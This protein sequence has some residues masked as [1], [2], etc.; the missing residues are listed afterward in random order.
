MQTGRRRRILQDYTME[1]IKPYKIK[2][3]LWKI[4][5]IYGVLLI[6]S[7]IVFLIYSLVQDYDSK[8]LAGNWSY[9]FFALQGIIFFTMGYMQLRYD[10]Y[11]IELNDSE[12]RYL[13]PKQKNIEHVKVVDIESVVIKLS[14]I[15][16]Y[17]GRET[18]TIPLSNLQYAELK[19]IKNKFEEINV[20][21]NRKSES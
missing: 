6:I 2:K 7:A 18:K 14:E 19:R 8:F 15:Q 20:T 5:L 10:R 12:I 21:V 4:M 3:V 16:I 17:M 13:L 1:T 9:V 11:F